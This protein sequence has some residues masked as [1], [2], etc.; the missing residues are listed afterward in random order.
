MMGAAQSMQLNHA[1]IPKQ[2]DEKQVEH[3]K[4]HNGQ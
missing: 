2:D 4:N 3:K 1:V